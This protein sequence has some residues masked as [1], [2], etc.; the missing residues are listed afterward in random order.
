MK[1]SLHQNEEN[2]DVAENASDQTVPQVDSPPL[3]PLPPPPP[4]AR[5]LRRRL[6]ARLPYQQKHLNVAVARRE[7]VAALKHR[8]ATAIQPKIEP[9]SLDFPASKLPLLQ[10]VYPHA[11]QP[12]IEP[13]RL[14]FSVASASKSPPLLLQ[15]G[16]SPCSWSCPHCFSPWPAVMLPAPPPPPDAGFHDFEVPWMGLGLELDVE[17]FVGKPYKVYIDGEP[18]VEFDEDEFNDEMPEF[19]PWSDDQ[20]EKQCEVDLQHDSAMPG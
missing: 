10:G 19:P 3:S 12:K 2:D 11:V 5:R 6:P 14:D 9:R 1:R 18:P 8:R 17:A 7:I 16:M 4:A 20:A 15:Q 13:R